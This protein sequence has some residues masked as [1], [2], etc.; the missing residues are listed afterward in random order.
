MRTRPSMLAL[1]IVAM[2]VLPMLLLVQGRADEI[3][4]TPEHPE[5]RIDLDRSKLQSLTEYTAARIVVRVAKAEDVAAL[6]VALEAEGSKLWE[7]Y[8]YT[9]KPGLVV[10]EVPQPI[11]EA[12]AA[13]SR[14]A[15]VLKAYFSSSSGELVV[16]GVELEAAP[17]STPTP[18]S[19]PPTTTPPSPV[20]GEPSLRRVAILLVQAMEALRGILDKLDQQTK[21]VVTQAISLLEKACTMIGQLEEEWKPTPPPAT[22]SPTTATPPKTIEAKT[23]KPEQPATKPIEPS[24]LAAKQ[25]E[26]LTAHQVPEKLSELASKLLEEAWK[27]LEKGDTDKAIQLAEQAAR[28]EEMALKLEQQRAEI[29]ATLLPLLTTNTTTR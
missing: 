17:P 18:P 6:A 13:S 9:I 29:L 22:P 4:L 1:V 23:T 27:A 14:V 3:H 2:V 11:I 25:I 20:A 10:F 26:R 12:A 16:T 5:A 21:P 15:L 24:T 19:P 7:D 28:L 8:A